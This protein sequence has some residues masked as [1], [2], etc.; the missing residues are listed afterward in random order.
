[1]RERARVALQAVVQRLGDVEEFLGALDDAPLDLE[2]NIGHQGYK[3]V[4]DLGDTTAER[5]RREVDHALALQRLGEP[6]NLADETA[7]GDRAVVGKALVP[8]ID[9]LEQS[10]GSLPLRAA[11]SWTAASRTAAANRRR[12]GGRSRARRR[13]PG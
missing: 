5:G 2:P 8:D 3:R 11:L 4:I 13:A 12:S 1:G 6:M 10:R 9:E 7:R